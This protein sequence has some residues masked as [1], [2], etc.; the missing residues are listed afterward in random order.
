MRLTF[1]Q[2]FLFCREPAIRTE[3]KMTKSKGRFE[4]LFEN[5]P[6]PTWV[7]DVETLRFLEVNG[8]ALRNYGFSRE[9]FLAMRITDIR[10]QE[11]VDQLL[12]QMK[13]QRPVVQSSERRHRCKD[14]RVIPVKV[15][16]H[17]AEVDRR[18]VAVVVAEDIGER[19]QAQEILVRSKED[20]E[21]AT[22][23]KDQFLSTM[24]HELRTPLNAILGFSELIA[25]ERYGTLNARQRRYADNIHKSGQ[26]LLR[27]I[28]DIL[29]LSKIEAGRL[30]LAMENVKIST[31][32]GEALAVMR[33][34]ADRKSHQLSQRAEKELYVRADAT[35]FKQA[36]LNL[37]GNA[38]K[39]TPAGGHI[40]LVASLEHG[41]VRVEVRDTGPGIAPDEQ[42]RIFEAFYRLRTSGEATEGTGLGLAITQRLVELH[43]SQLCLDSELGKGSC[44]YFF[45]PVV[46]EVARSGERGGKTTRSSQQAPRIFVIEDDAATA[47]LI[48][49]YL[50]SAGYETVFCQTTRD[51]LEEVVDLQPE[52]IT[53]DLFMRPTNGWDVLVQLKGDE[54]TKAIPVIVV[55]MVD[56]PGM[57]A[58]LGAD[59]YLMKPVEKATLVAAVER[60]VR[61]RGGTPPNQPILVVEDDEPTR[62]LI[63]QLLQTSGFAVRTVSDGAQARDSV[64]TSLPALVILDLLLPK[65][66]GFDLIAE[67]RTDPRTAD[68]PVFV[69]TSK[70]LSHDETKYLRA[71]AEFLEHKQHDWQEALLKH[72]QRAVPERQL[73]MP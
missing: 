66:G 24:S 13:E 37:I 69:L 57:G 72:L 43:E 34:L 47:Q 65:V 20:A 55:T 22:R 39:F 68:L 71:N 53:L 31:A 56:Q 9:E 30:E 6:Y 16:S 54:R 61:S 60:C 33:P 19:K 58:I 70:D 52:A 7:Y 27:L 73:E 62:E 50:T 3:A 45:L 4:I 28:N 63:T 29:D 44:F 48:S 40:Q 8:A 25:D 18:T 2:R 35:R 14:G 23:F 46:T 32:F 67:W 1:V 21:R 5:N 11:D 49:S 12:K 26:H 17:L 51:A 42:K 41:R 38:V 36:L 15:T 10:P 59:D 64:A